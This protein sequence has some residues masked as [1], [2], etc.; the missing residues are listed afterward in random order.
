MKKQTCV[1]VL[2]V[3][4]IYYRVTGLSLQRTKQIKNIVVPPF[5]VKGGSK[6]T[7]VPLFEQKVVVTFGFFETTYCLVCI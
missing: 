5:E 7:L 4:S 1:V 6:G 2:Q 3:N